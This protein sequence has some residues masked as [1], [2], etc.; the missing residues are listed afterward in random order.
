MGIYFRP[1]GLFFGLSL[2]MA[3]VLVAPASAAE[4]I[5]KVDLALTALVY[6]P[7]TGKLYGAS[8]NNLLQID[9]DSGRV[10]RTFD[11]GSR[12]FRI[13]LGAG[14]GIW[15]AVDHAL[16]RFNLETLAAEDPIAI[17]DNVVDLSPSQSEPHTVAFSTPRISGRWETGWLVRNGIILPGVIEHG[18]FVAVNGN[19]FFKDNHRYPIGPNGVVNSGPIPLPTY[20]P[21]RMKPF[22]SYIYN[23]FGD[24][25]NINTVE[26]LPGTPHVV[27]VGGI[28]TINRAENALYYVTLIDDSTLDLDRFEHLTFKHTGHYRVRNIEA[29][30][31]THD[32]WVAAWSTNRV[33]FHT[34][35]KLYLLDTAQLF[36]PADLVVTQTVQPSASVGEDYSLTLKVANEGP[37]AALNV[38][39]SNVLSSGIIRSINQQLQIDPFVHPS[40]FTNNLGTIEPGA[41]I[42]LHLGILPLDVHT[43]SNLFAVTS[44][45]DPNPAN[46]SSQSQ[47][48]IIRNSA[49]VTELPFPSADLAYDPLRKR[50]FIG[51]G[52]A[53]WAYHRD[54]DQIRLMRVEHPRDEKIEVSDAGGTV[55]R[56]A[57]GYF[58]SYDSETLVGTRLPAPANIIN[59]FAVSPLNPNL[60]VFSEARGTYLFSSGFGLPNKITE[61][62]TVAFSSD[63][64][65]VYFQNASDCSLS[66]LRVDPNGL[67]LEL[68][69]SNL[70]CGEFTVSS[71]LLYFN[72]GVIYDPASG[73]VAAN[74]FSLTPPSYVV[75]RAGTYIDILNRT[76]DAWV[77]RRLSAATLQPIMTV[78]IDPVFGTPL[79]MVAMDANTV[80]VRTSGAG[81]RV[82]VIDLN[83]RGIL[84]ADLTVSGAGQLTLSFFSILGENYR[85]ERSSTLVNPAWT[86]VRDNI[87]GNGGRID[88]IIPTNGPASYFRVVRL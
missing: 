36:L 18:T 88:E 3:S 61:Q 32:R 79:E 68:T 38:N 15:T 82:L 27:G 14:N 16:R 70:A 49:T 1:A 51:S 19:Y 22:G 48:S 6:D 33:A 56:F 57:A 65:R 53:L 12:I 69:R 23:A 37:G 31:P 72:N 42:E 54:L 45:D 39:Y 28:F 50:L 41:A 11:L 85:I 84:N 5:R 81:A 30:T 2:L 58:Y 24:G 10:L 60:Q 46:N 43:I 21:S 62:G 9:P 4:A 63:G 26:P 35:S 75:P 55:F 83:D 17:V 13:E 44:N 66:V 77:V 8:T 73:Q 40:V 86:T 34:S 76:N 7:F 74:S 87:P 20:R 52:G 64:T 59:D 80:A 47:I 25:W 67:I 78:P 29:D 71:N